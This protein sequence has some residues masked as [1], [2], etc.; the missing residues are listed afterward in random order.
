MQTDP[1]RNTA[2]KDQIQDLSLQRFL[3]VMLLNILCS[4]IKISVCII[5]LSILTFCLYGVDISYH[6]SSYPD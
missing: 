6:L 2:M 1:E 3:Y 4:E 5:I